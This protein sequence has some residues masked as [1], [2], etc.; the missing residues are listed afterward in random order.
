MKGM[1]FIFTR[2]YS[3]AGTVFEICSIYESIHEMCKDYISEDEADFRIEICLDDIELERKLS[4]KTDI[5]E[6][7]KPVKY[8]DGYL[9]TLAV[10]RKMCTELQAK[11][12]ILYHGSVIAVDGE[13]FLFTAKSGTGKSTHTANWRKYFGDRAVMVNDDK[14]LLKITDNGVIAYGTPWDGKHHLSTNMSIPLKAVCILTRSETNMIE[15]IDPH[16]Y[17]GLLLQQ[18]FRPKDPVKLA[19]VLNLIERFFKNTEFYKL[20]C[21][22]DISSA[23]VAYNG[24]KG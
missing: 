4:E 18:A 19:G 24:M 7:R 22:M 15:K 12:T 14:P 20:G 8:K 16:E 2:K 6:G 11:D 17:F 3:F 21:N 1:I 23:E 5:A 13:A 9:E 10:Y